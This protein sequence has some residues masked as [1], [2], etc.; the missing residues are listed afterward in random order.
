MRGIC[1][2]HPS[3]AEQNSLGHAH[4]FDHDRTFV[5]PRANLCLITGKPRFAVETEQD[6]KDGDETK[7]Q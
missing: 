7:G 4:A 6:T 5:G 3:N 2:K 1:L